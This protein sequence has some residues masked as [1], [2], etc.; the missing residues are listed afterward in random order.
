[1]VD[2]N[3]TGNACR[4]INSNFSKKVNCRPEM[5]VYTSVEGRNEV[6][7]MIVSTCTIKAGSELY[8]EYGNGYWVPSKS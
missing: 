6:V 1:M 2:P 3:E 4:F 8:Y 5:G 7:V